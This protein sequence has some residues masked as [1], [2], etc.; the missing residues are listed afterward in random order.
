MIVLAVLLG[1]SAAAAAPAH[2]WTDAPASPSRPTAPP[3]SIA[4]LVKASMP[5]VVGI[6][7]V[8]ARMGSTD[9]FHDFL[10][11]MYGNGGAER[12]QPVR[13]I[14]TGSSSG[15]TASW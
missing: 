13:G 10:E 12:E 4:A 7:A 15:P 9:P 11:R 2:P 1:A 5:A 6:V 3:Q 8:T 14:G